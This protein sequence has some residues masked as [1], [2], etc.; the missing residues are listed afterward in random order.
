M[1]RLILLAPILLTFLPI[2]AQELDEAFLNSLPKDI[3]EDIAKKSAENGALEDPIYRSIES[4]TK[5]EKKKLSDLKTRLEDDLKYLEEKLADEDFEVNTNDL[6][7]FGSEFFSTYQSTF[8]P[9]NE[10]NLSSSYILDYGD[11]LE[12][13]LIGKKNE[14]EKYQIKRD[15]SINLPD[16]G[17]VILL[18][19]SLDDA[20]LLI[21][22][23][24]DTT[25][26]GTEAFI[27]LNS[28]RDINV[29]VSGNAYNPGIYT[30]SGNANLLHVLG[31]AGGIN[32]YGSY[33]EI[34]LIRDKK[35]IETLDMYDVLITGFYNSQTTLKSGDTIFVKPVKNIVSIDGAVK[36]PAKFEL[37]ENQNLYDLIDY[38]NGTSSDADLQN[39][40]L[41]RILDG[42]IKS[43]PIR[44]ISQFKTIP[45]KDGDSI[46]IRKHKFRN[47]QIDG[48]VLKPGRYLMA[49]GESLNDLIKKAGGL[50][51][52][53]YPFGAVY[54]NQRAFIINKMAK[55]KLYEEFIDNIITVSQKNPTGNFDLTAVLD[56]TKNLKDTMPNGRVGIDLLDEASTGAL[57]IQDG[58]ILTIPEKSNHIYIYG[59]VNYEGALK[60]INKEDVDYY[61]NKSGG[62]KENASKESIYVLHPNGDTQRFSMGR[63][64]VFQ[65]SPSAEMQL[66]PGSVIFVPRGID[67]S[68]TNR[69]AA[70][71]YVSILGN[72]GIALASLS[73]INNNN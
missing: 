40:S 12:I 1:K 15:G 6:K 71:A 69:L 3:Q 14:K 66:Y 70:Q 31:V 5:L 22:S 37:F 8:M 18:G 48:A 61:I 73:S 26:I 24:I 51:I 57:V 64:N 67:N 4:Q 33:R 23:K 34:N 56:L 27:S 10:P 63:K 65:N 41:D 7:L 30:V 35:I 50:T 39:I 55:D 28:V 9:I 58:D 32:E 36:I 53:A 20:S 45:S 72:I 43:L 11:V 46:Y 62:L 25:Y 52:N 60:F 19:L 13:Q 2:H 38:A 49:D 17:P 54:E 29:L 44:N 68:A 59:E 21:K 42:K 16:I 47:V